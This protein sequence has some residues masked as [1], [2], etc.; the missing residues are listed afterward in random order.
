[1]NKHGRPRPKFRRAVSTRSPA[2]PELSDQ[3]EFVLKTSGFWQGAYQGW[4]ATALEQ[5]RS[6]FALASA[7]VG[8]SL[9]LLFSEKVQPMESWAPVWLLLS[10]VSF[11]VASSLT[12]AVFH[13]NKRVLGK[14]I[15]D[16]SSNLEESL[17]GRLDFAARLAFGAGLIFLV[18]SAVS[19]IWL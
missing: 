17:V 13:F 16:E 10:T 8:L 9:T 3:E 6:V 12:V 1:M 7:G 14:L 5:T 2:E 11:V 18:F 15:S 4:F 19:Q